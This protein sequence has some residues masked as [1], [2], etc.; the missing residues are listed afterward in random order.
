VF[1]NLHLHAK[2]L[3][4]DMVG[5]FWVILPCLLSILITLEIIKNE[6]SGPNV[7]EILKRT[8]LCVIMLWSFDFVISA[9]ASMFDIREHIIY[10]FAIAAY[11]IAYIGFFASTALVHFVWAILYI[12]APLLLPCFISPKT[13]QITGNLYRGLINVAAWKIMW[14]LLGS[15]LLKMALSPNIV[16]I[17]DYFL[18]MVINLLIGISMLVIPFFTKSL[19]S[20]GLQSAASGLAV[21][22]GLLA[23]K[24]AAMAA[25]KYTKKGISK[26]VD[27]LNFASKPLTNPLTSRAKILGNKMKLK[28]R[29]NRAKRSYGQVGI[30]SELKEENKRQQRKKY[31]IRD[32]YNKKRGKQSSKRR[33]RKRKR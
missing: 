9:I 11:L 7:K 25:K 33:T 24:S 23:A 2:Q 17:E 27:G 18:S 20:D 6:D 32:N 30:S 31:A 19:I 3:H 4:G 29:F 28:E 14:T 21:A 8:V 13:A 5:V 16:G 22:P 10:F 26:G 15:L 1:E 12:T